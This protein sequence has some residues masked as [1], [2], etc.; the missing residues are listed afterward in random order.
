[1]PVHNSDIANILNNVADLLDI[2]GKNQFR[3][4]AYRTAAQSIS[5][6][7]QSV[8]GMLKEGKNLSQLPN[9]GSRIADKIQEIVETGKLKELETLEKKLPE[10]LLDLMKIPNVGPSKVRTM[11]QEL[12]INAVDELQKAAEDGR[13]QGLKGFGKKTE[14]KILQELKRRQQSETRS[15][16]LLRSGLQVDLR[17]VTAES[18]GAAL[19]YF[20]G[21]KDHNIAI[22]KIAVSK[23]LKINEY[24]VFRNEDK[25][26][27]GKSEDEVYEQIGLSYIEPELRENRGEIEAAQKNK[28]PKLITLEDIQG[29]LQSHTKA[30]DGKFELKEMAEGAREKGYHYLAITEHSKRVTMA[31]GLDEKRLAEQIEEIEKLNEH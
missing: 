17:A 12:G 1:M 23:K 10:S 4:R 8:A 13:I 16:V 24:G 19:V 9:I 30:S 29:D 7:S 26:I 28:L 6:L 22:R 18:Y 20:T 27:A 3:I 25:R 5:G 21:C 14:Q 2:Q 15:S 31:H 11:H